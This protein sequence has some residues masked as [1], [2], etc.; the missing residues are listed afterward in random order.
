MG[1]TSMAQARRERWERAIGLAI[2]FILASTVEKAESDVTQL[3][4][5]EDVPSVGESE[6]AL[7]S[8]LNGTA[9]VNATKVK[10]TKPKSALEKEIL[11]KKPTVSLQSV[12]AK[13]VMTPKAVRASARLAKQLSGIVDAN[14]KAV[15]AKPVK[16]P[17][18]TSY[19]SASGAKKSDSTTLPKA[20]AN[21]KL[22][23]AMMAGQ[24]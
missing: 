6:S 20:P 1:T 16:D 2:I 10:K 9:A 5:F 13:E 8:V 4:P 19:Q 3:D 11:K 21:P 14:G 23:N 18:L 24:N 12:E 7:V 22:V 15:L 17:I